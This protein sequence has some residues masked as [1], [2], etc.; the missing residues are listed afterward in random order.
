[1]LHC[2]PE[3]L[4]LAALREPLPADDAAHLAVCPSCARELAALRR[5]VDAL[6][7][8]HLAAPSGAVIPP[9]SVWDA[10]EARTGVTIRPRP[11]VVAS[12]L[13][14]AP[15]PRPPAPVVPLRRPPRLRALLVAVA[16]LVV[17]AGV[18]AGVVALAGRDTGTVV[19]STALRPLP[20]A[21]ASGS[22]RVVERDGARL[23]EV[24]LRAP[25]PGDDDFY[26]VW[27]ADPDLQGM[28][29][30]GAV[31]SG[32]TDLPLPDGLDVG[33]FP[34]VDVSVE[35]FDGDPAHSAESVARGRL[36]S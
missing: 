27:L 24:Q 12:P 34:V 2:T 36:G 35:P 23:L 4:A 13:L 11:E 33:R 3:Q 16:A 1:M 19:A 7:V 20:E 15:E 28:Y 26:E 29:A 5:S 10:I 14:P 17:G 32:T 8:P 21:T 31:H 30:V 18:G 22:A 6:A 25:A 9:P